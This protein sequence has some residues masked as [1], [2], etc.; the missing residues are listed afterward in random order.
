MRYSI[1]GFSNYLPVVINLLMFAIF[2]RFDLEK[3]LPAMR[4]EVA[5]RKAARQ[6][7]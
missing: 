5:E 2:T 6:Q 1:Y 3:K 4:Q 7:K